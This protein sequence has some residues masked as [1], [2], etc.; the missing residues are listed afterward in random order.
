M[1]ITLGVAAEVVMVIQNKNFFVGP[2][3][4]AVKDSRRQSTQARANHHEIIVFTRLAHVI[5][6]QTAAPSMLVRHR[7]GAWMAAP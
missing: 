7:I 6:A 4:L 2:M 1:F 5:G 3:L